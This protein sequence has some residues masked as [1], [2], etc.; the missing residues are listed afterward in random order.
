[1]SAD[2][3]YKEAMQSIKAMEDLVQ[4]QADLADYYANMDF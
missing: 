4:Y 3:T 1:M 2:G